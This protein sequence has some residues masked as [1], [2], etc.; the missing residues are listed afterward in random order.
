MMQKVNPGYEE[1]FNVLMEALEQTQNG[2]GKERHATSEPFEEQEICKI[3]EWVGPGYQGGQAI[4]K[5]K[6][7][8]RLPTTEA[9]EELLGSI[10]YTVALV[11]QR[12][13][14]VSVYG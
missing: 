3:G 11:L 7:S 8:Y 1:V 14:G 9:V 4:K 13:K 2:K 12:R 6:E 5:I 10:I